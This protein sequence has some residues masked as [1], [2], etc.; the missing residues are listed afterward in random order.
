MAI[1]LVL[2]P[3]AIVLGL[4]GLAAFLWALHN[5]QFE[6]LEDHAARILKPDDD[7]S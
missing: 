1:M 4:A 5:G 6:D 7:V 3:L 2:I